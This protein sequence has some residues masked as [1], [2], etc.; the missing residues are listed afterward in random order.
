MINTE[1]EAFR[2]YDFGKDLNMKKYGQST[3]PDYDIPSINFPIALFGG[4]N[5][6]VATTKDIA[7]INLQLKENVVFSKTDYPL[8]HHSF[9][10]AKN[11]D[12]FTKDA[13]S[14]L[15]RFNKI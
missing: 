4:A 2:R 9:V 12:F 7:W 1:K 3:P 15:N 5:D 10:I 13:M 8:D 14:I 11:L 6:N